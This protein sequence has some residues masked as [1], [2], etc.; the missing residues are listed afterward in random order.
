MFTQIC[1]VSRSFGKQFLGED[2]VKQKILDQFRLN[3]GESKSKFL[4][5][6]GEHVF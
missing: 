1:R 2:D 3:L 6:V 4:L 5:V